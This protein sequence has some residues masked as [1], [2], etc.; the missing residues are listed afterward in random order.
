MTRR[1]LPTAADVRA[2]IADLRRARER[3][4]KR[5]APAMSP[6]WARADGTCAICGAEGGVAKTD[7]LALCDRSLA[8]LAVSAWLPEGPHVEQVL[9]LVESWLGP[10]PGE[11]ADPGSRDAGGSCSVCARA[12][13]ELPVLVGPGDVLLC[14][15]CIASAMKVV[16]P[17]TRD[18][19]FAN[20]TE[21][22]I[23]EAADLE[24]LAGSQG[25]ASLRSNPTVA[26]SLIRMLSVHDERVHERVATLARLLSG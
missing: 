13:S 22:T 1:R 16:D 24:R 17:A 8:E 20:E 25:A 11:P 3:D 15:D 6:A 7:S 9:A 23:H 12:A 19:V 2:A 4:A 10:I 18:E 26:L 14:S 21:A 5:A